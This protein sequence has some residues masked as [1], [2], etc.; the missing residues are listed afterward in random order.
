MVSISVILPTARENDS[1]IGLPN[2]N[3]FQSTIESLK[4][5]SF[6]DFELIVID[7]LYHLRVGLFE[8]EPFDRKKLEFGIKHIPVEHNQKYNHRFWL[9]NRR[10]AVA[11]TLNTGLIHAEGELVVRIDDACQFDS[12]YLSRIWSEYKVNKLWLCGMHIRYLEGKPA[13]LD[14]KYRKIGYEMN[15]SGGWD[16]VRRD[17]ILK[18]LYGEGGLVRDSRYQKVV[19]VGGR[20]IAP[21]DWS[22]GYSCFELEAALRVNGFCELMDGDKSLEDVDFGNR[23]SMAGY[24]GKFL[25]D[26]NHQVIE[27][28]HLGISSRIIDSGVKPIK[29]NYSLY[30]LNNNKKRWRVNSSVLDS[31]ELKFVR[32]ESLKS[33]CSPGGVGGYYDEDCKG[34]LFDI[35]SKNQPQF[36]LR[37]E[38]KLYGL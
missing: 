36:D 12:L 8:G 38:R 21:S 17:E 22:Y 30:L 6:K 16:T 4:L 20:M 2:V 29:C 19:D 33:P 32:N 14:E 5:Q 34:R 11:A 25:L 28:E 18:K 23:L 13:I 37:E 7:G 26:V 27:H 9:D 15:V 35:W 1:I 31:K 3:I 10:W 24:S